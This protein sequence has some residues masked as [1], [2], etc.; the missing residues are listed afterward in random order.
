MENCFINEK[1]INTLIEQAKDCQK[2]AILENA[3][4]S[5]IRK[6][7][8]GIT[9]NDNTLISTMKSLFPERYAALEKSWAEEDA[10][11]PEGDSE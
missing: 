3:L 8:Y 5:T 4:F 9:F 2:A 11:K 10:K 1:V 7:S 6:M